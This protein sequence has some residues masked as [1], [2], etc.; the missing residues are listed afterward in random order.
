MSRSLSDAVRSGNIAE[1]Q[2]RLNMGEDTDQADPP[3]YRSALH[4]AVLCGHLDIARL[5][6]SS[7]AGVDVGDR[8]GSTPLA[9]AKRDQKSEFVELLLHAGGG[10][11]TSTCISPIPELGTDPLLRDSPPWSVSNIKQYLDTPLEAGDV[12]VGVGVPVGGEQKALGQQQG[13]KSDF[14]SFFKPK[15]KESREVEI[16]QPVTSEISSENPKVKKF[17]VKSFVSS[18]TKT[19]ELEEPIEVNTGPKSQDSVEGLMSNVTKTNKNPFEDPI[20]VNEEPKS[21]ISIKGFMTNVIKPNEKC[22]EDLV[23]FD[24]RPASQASVK[25]FISNI[26]KTKE[27][28][29]EDPT[30][31]NDRPKSQLSIKG[32]ISN[33]IKPKEKVVED[34]NEVN[35]RPKSQGSIKDFMSNV[36][37]P[38][39]KCLE[40]TNED[41][42][43][44]KSQ[45]S[46]KDFMSNVIKQKEKCVEDPNEVNDRPKSQ[47]SVKDFMSNMIK[48]KEK[49]IEKPSEIEG[50]LIPQASIHTEIDSNGIEL[51]KEKPEEEFTDIKNEKSK[52]KDEGKDST[53]IPAH[54]QSIRN[55][56]SLGKDN[57]SNWVK[58]KEEKLPQSFKK[59]R[60]A[61]NE[62]IGELKKKK[63][64]E[65][66]EED[67]DKIE[68]IIGNISIRDDLPTGISEKTDDITN[69]NEKDSEKEKSNISKSVLKFNKIRD[70]VTNSKFNVMKSKKKNGAVVNEAKPPKHP[71]NETSWRNK[72]TAA[73]NY[74]SNSLKTSVKKENQDSTP[75]GKSTKSQ[76]SFRKVPTPSFNGTTINNV[77]SNI[78]KITKDTSDKT[79]GEVKTS[80]QSSHKKL[81]TGKFTAVKEHVG[82]SFKSKPKVDQKEN[83]KSKKHNKPVTPKIKGKVGGI[84]KVKGS[85]KHQNKVNNTLWSNTNGTNMDDEPF[86]GRSVKDYVRM[87]EEKHS[88]SCVENTIIQGYARPFKEFTES[89]M[90]QNSFQTLESV[91]NEKGKDT[92]V[93]I[94]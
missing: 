32:F 62:F 56:C 49:C 46:I 22:A 20:E 33:V 92:A 25:G 7:G 36:I 15:K 34:Q 26:I 50:S 78:I 74:A 53:R 17:I 47:A 23:E 19:K 51:N 90:S 55:K 24:E 57:I 60:L 71:N 11:T 42:E 45:A 16:K 1:V 10:A 38:K 88:S 82:K 13:T 9:L 84:F 18:S 76:S 73:K 72:Y 93:S 3:L 52:V 89:S 41:N 86:V 79:D 39:G 8:N 54:L 12:G 83:N 63:I 75:K 43:R 81:L 68:T 77:K 87:F 59:K 5:L 6:V 37:K 61:A 4:W 65:N 48:T 27:K 40:D 80:I 28:S 69:E 30:E 21:Q 2:I 44:P 14:R 31:V 29:V 64:K 70:S 91:A 67:E 58:D 35:D 85:P 66:F 94:R